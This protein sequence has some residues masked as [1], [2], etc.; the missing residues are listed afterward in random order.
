M[1]LPDPTPAQAVELNELF[2]F[3]FMLL[4]VVEQEEE[5]EKARQEAEAAERERVAQLAA[6]VRLSPSHLSCRPPMPPYPSPSPTHADKHACLCFQMEIGKERVAH[7]EQLFMERL[8]ARQAAEAAREASR[9]VPG[10]TFPF[11]FSV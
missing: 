7:R 3:S 8:Q 5:R 10:H 2:M 6:E 9:E 4:G 11:P 1:Y